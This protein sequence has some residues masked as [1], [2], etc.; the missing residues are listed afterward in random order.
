[1][2]ERLLPLIKASFMC[3]SQG[4]RKELLKKVEERINKAEMR[5]DPSIEN[6]KEVLNAFV[7]KA[8]KDPSKKYL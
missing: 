1:V 6:Y 5:R 3:Y 4:T 7:N 2:R 8:K